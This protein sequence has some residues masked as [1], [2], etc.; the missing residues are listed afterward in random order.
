MSERSDAA[1]QIVSALEN[2]G[3]EASTWTEAV[4]RG[5]IRKVGWG[6]KGRSG[7]VVLVDADDIE[8]F[9]SGSGDYADPGSAASAIIDAVGDE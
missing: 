8:V 9:G 5:R 7:A 2:A 6:G 3:L 4:T 1:E